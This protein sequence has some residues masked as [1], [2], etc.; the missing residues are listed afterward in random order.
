MT[1]FFY[2]VLLIAMGNYC[3][4][5][6]NKL[7]DLLKSYNTTIE[8]SV[9]FNNLAP[10]D[11]ID[12]TLLNKVLFDMQTSRAKVYSKEGKLFNVTTYGKVEEEPFVWR[13]WSDETKTKRI[14][15]KFFTTVYSLGQLV[16]DPNFK[17]IVTKIVGFEKTYI[18]LYVFNNDGMLTS[19]INLYEVDYKKNGDPLEV[20]TTYIQSNISNDGI[21]RWQEERFNVKTK[22][23]YQLQPDGYF[24]IIEQTSEGQFEY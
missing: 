16:L 11:T 22:R 14:E 10:Q 24:K 5:Q 19:L 9:S 17:L 8:S 12:K 2:I 1:R 4:A 15:K 6:N 23:E 18:D 3:E 21:I 13:T 7:D 20:K